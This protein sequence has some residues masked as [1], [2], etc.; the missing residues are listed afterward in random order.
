MLCTSLRYFCIQVILHNISITIIYNQT[1]EMAL[2]LDEWKMTELEIYRS[3]TR[4]IYS[5]SCC[6]LANEVYGE[7]K[8]RR[9]NINAWHHNTISVHFILESNKNVKTHHNSR[10]SVIP[11]SKNRC[12]LERS[13]STSTLTPA[14]ASNSK[15]RYNGILCTGRNEGAKKLATLLQMN[16]WV[17]SL[18]LCEI[19]V[20]AT[21]I[22]DIVKSLHQYNNSLK[23]LTL[24]WNSIDDDGVMAIADLVQ[25][26]KSIRHLD[27]SYNYISSVGI[28]AIAVALRDNMSLTSIDLRGNNIGEEGAIALLGTLQD[29]NDTLTDLKFT[30]PSQS[31]SESTLLIFERI[32]HF[33]EENHQGSRVA[34]RKA[35]RRRFIISSWLLMQWVPMT[36]PF[37]GHRPLQRKKRKT[38][39]K[40]TIDDPLNATFSNTI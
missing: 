4:I 25:Y 15:K 37:T 23:S 11:L 21:G 10:A 22:T 12:S 7:E 27:V 20:S 18:T 17:T 19:N 8:F 34:P 14:L 2:L 24:R 39:L 3:M 30:L 6:P 26:N 28:A 5:H 32:V 33:A 31:V 29:W 16:P 38:K 13:L 35:E 1:L 9:S 40:Y 36:N